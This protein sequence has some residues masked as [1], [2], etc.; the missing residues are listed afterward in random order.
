LF[1]AKSTGYQIAAFARRNVAKKRAQEEGKTDG[2]IRKAMIRLNSRFV[3]II[4][5]KCFPI[6]L[7][8]CALLADVSGTVTI[9]PSGQLDLDSGVVK[10]S[11]GGDG[12][13]DWSN[14]AGFPP[15]GS[16]TFV[17]H[18][19]VVPGRG[20]DFFNTLTAQTL[21]GYPYS[22][23][24]LTTTIQQG[25]SNAYIFASITKCGNYSKVLLLAIGSSLQVQFTTYIPN[26]GGVCPSISGFAN[27]Y[28]PAGV[29]QFGIAPGSL[30]ILAGNKLNDMPL[31]SLQSSAAPGLPT[32][33]NGTTMSVTV[34]GV[35]TTP[36][37]YY[38][39]QGQIG[40]V[41]PSNTPTGVATLNI[42]NNGV[43]GAPTMINVVPSAVGLATIDGSGS[44]A[45]VATD[46]NSQLISRENPARP[47]QT[48][49]LWGSGVGA[50]LSNDDRT[51]P[52]KQN[53][54]TAIPFQVYFGTTPGTVLYRGRSQFPGVDQIVVVVPQDVSPGCVVSVAAVAAEFLSNT[55]TIPISRDGSACSD[56]ILSAAQE[57]SLFAA[58]G[59]RYGLIRLTSFNLAL[60]NG[61]YAY[62]IK[63]GTTTA[64]T[65]P[66]VGSCLVR[67][68]APPPDTPDT[69]LDAGNLTVSVNG[70]SPRPMPPQSGVYSANLPSF[71]ASGTA[72]TFTGSG[73]KDAGPFSAI[74]NLLPFTMVN[75]DAPVIRS[76]GHHI[77]WQGGDPA[78]YVTIGTTVRNFDIRCTAPASAGEFTLPSW[79]TS[80][81]P[82][83]LSQPFYIENHSAPQVLAISG[84][85]LAFVYGQSQ[86]SFNV[87][88][89]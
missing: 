47:G 3:S 67:P 22:T 64:T 70:G 18:A 52:L 5:R 44:G 48:I 33:L 54:L 86:D 11:T 31:T 39:S 51:Y 25:P 71:P 41:L 34:N 29:L 32:T 2:T 7:L 63:K 88:Y 77:S 15:G 13:L 38:T 53:N 1:K 27:N 87:P 81:M 62:F 89:Q 28:A 74:G 58:P 68:L 50:D 69:Y 19:Y 14:S 76:Q 16:L 23:F 17:H 55:A 9:P 79:L 45:V 10:P 43:A 80:A 21:A 65:A 40:A 6:V 66:S 20:I 73:G 24:G 12:D 83:S 82:T 84:L 35:T 85:D 78:T 30:F 72:F 60:S 56:L 75:T 61:A 57:P 36:G 4:L 59:T 49:V 37:L 46:A 8:P 42:T 26:G